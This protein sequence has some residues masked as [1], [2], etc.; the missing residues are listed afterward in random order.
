MS[1]LAREPL[2]LKDVRSRVYRDLWDWG[3]AQ[4]HGYIPAKRQDGNHSG[5][6]PSSR[7]PLPDRLLDIDRGFH[8][9]NPTKV[10]PIRGVRYSYLARQQFNR[11][12]R[13]VWLFYVGDTDHPDEQQRE[14]LGLGWLA[15]DHQRIIEKYPANVV[16]LK[17]DAE[18]EQLGEGRDWR[19]D[20]A[21]GE[22][23]GIGG[24]QAHRLRCMAIFQ[25][26]NFV[27][28]ELLDDGSDMH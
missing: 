16:N 8:A 24:R 5:A 25:I 7:M 15:R 11:L 9:L 14:P 1:A 28:W 4:Q 10:I 26:A 6:A 17:R 2:T 18:T 3:Q 23:L 19:G 13:V 22:R 27:K 21:V 20:G 12:Q